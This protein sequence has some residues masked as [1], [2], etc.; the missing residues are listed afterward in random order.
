[1]SSLGKDTDIKVYHPSVFFSLVSNAEQFFKSEII[2]TLFACGGYV[3]GGFLRNLI[4]HGTVDA[5]DQHM[6]IGGD[7]DF[8]FNSY[9]G[10]R[11]FK[12]KTGYSIWAPTVSGNAEETFLTYN[13]N[14]EMRIKTQIIPLFF[15]QP[16][17]QIEGFDFANVAVAY[18]GANFYMS[19]K[20]PELEKKNV[21]DFNECA[22]IQYTLGYRLAKYFRKY[23][24]E[25]ITR[26]SKLLFKKWL[27]NVNKTRG[28]PSS[29][30]ST[31]EVLSDRNI[32]GDEELRKFIGYFKSNSYCIDY[33]GML[34][35][36]FHDVDLAEH[37]LN[38]RY[39]SANVDVGDLV[40]IIDFLNKDS[41][42]PAIILKKYPLRARV[43]L[44]GGEIVSVEYGVIRNVLSKL[45]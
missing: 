44:C 28:W 1:M 17:K 8:F 13:C 45:D 37:A 39:W 41:Y 26:R 24:Y 9:D 38:I 16:A 5:I 36:H 25:K 23:H 22:V 3:A 27:V 7:I 19:E 4:R 31:L 34:N 32:I 42:T 18:D 10:F 11:Q 20:L 40:E 35:P 43:A 2:Q 33:S 14:R 15:G 30:P 29:H 12:E 6:K 21:L